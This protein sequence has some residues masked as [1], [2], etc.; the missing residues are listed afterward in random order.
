MSWELGLGAWAGRAWAGSLAQKPSRGAWSG[1]RSWGQE[2]GLGPGAEAGSLGLGWEFG[3]G[4][5]L[6]LVLDFLCMCMNLG[7]RSLYGLQSLIKRQLYMCSCSLCSFS[8][9]NNICVRKPIN[10]CSFK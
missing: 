1:S 6:G 2:P 10:T 5:G 7:I 3:S 4:A 8:P 9:N